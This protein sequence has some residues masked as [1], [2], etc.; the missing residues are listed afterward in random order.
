MN[1]Q[2]PVITVSYFNTMAQ[3]LDGK[4]LAL[5]IQAEL[6]T[7]IQTWRSQ[8][9]RPPGLAVL[10]VGDHP[11]SATYVR[12]KARAC[13]RVGIAA[14]GQT[15]STKTDQA[16]LAQVIA[17]L[18]RDSQVDGILVQL[19][20]P[21]HLDAI[22][23]LNQIAPDKDA[24]GLHPL[25]LGRLLR[26]EPGLRS[27][28]PAGV[29]Q[30]LSAY[31]IPLEGKTAA[32]LGRSILVGKPMA[33]MLLAANATPIMVHSRSKNLTELTRSADILVTAVGSPQLIRGDQVKPGATVIDVG[34]SRIVDPATGR[35]R[36]VG[37]V[38]F[39]SVSP[40]A[41]WI[42]PVPGGV[43]PMT[44]TMLLHN[45]VLSYRKRFQID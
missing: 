23:L 45:T 31:N 8:C 2:P 33:I 9:G 25:N 44:V 34:I 24:D 38:D 40:L 5:K 27:C 16:Q 3:I 1:E 42:T 17:D 14:L 29:M 43:G 22:A 41:E 32:V 37:D 6:A 11:A 15:F 12:N 13:E 35:D 20:L 21:E 18:N 10:M 19:P 7:H 28:T 39:E 30:L 4:A 36:L 26:D